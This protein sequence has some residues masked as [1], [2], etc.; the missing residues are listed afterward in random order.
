[1]TFR[2][3]VVLALITAAFYAPA[4]RTDF[5]A[6]DRQ[7]I[8]KN[9]LADDVP[10]ALRS[11]VEDY[12]GALGGE[13]FVYFRP[14]TVLTH[15]IDTRLWGRSPAGHHASNI[16]L[17]AIVTLLVFAF[18]L[19]L[20][21]G[22]DR[23]CFAGALLFG[24]H[25]IHTHSVIYVVGRTDVL[26][27]LFCLLSLLVLCRQRCTAAQQVLGALFYLAALLCKEIAVTLPLLYALY[28]LAAPGGRP[29]A[30]QI[31]RA[32]VLLAAALAL[33]L[34]MRVQAVGAGAGPEA[35]VSYGPV[36]RVLLV[37]MTLGFYCAKLLMPVNLCYYS[38]LVVPHPGMAAPDILLVAGGVLCAALMCMFWRRGAA[39]MALAWTGI[40]LLPVL[41]IIALPVLAKENYLYLPSV[42][43]CLLAALAA[44]RAGRL[45]GGRIAALLVAAIALLYGMQ[46]CLRTLDYRDPAL[47]L[48]SAVRAMR[49]LSRD[50]VENKNCFEGAKNWFTTCRN[51]GYLYVEKNSPAEAEQWFERA[52]DFTPAYFDPRYGAECRQALGE[53]YLK[54]GR[55][56]EARSQLNAALTGAHRPQVVYNLLGAAAAMQGDLQAAEDC[57]VQALAI[58]PGF[59][60]ARDNLERLRKKRAPAGRSS[61]PFSR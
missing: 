18:F 41:N 3:A 14:L 29:S 44:G 49:P 46:L 47:Y 59:A 25:P 13:S 1:M 54:Q 9:E 23:V 58:D 61:A 55:V 26:A 10:T 8:S 30:A 11:F 6:G 52:L 40:T 2:L 50:E 12:W 24:L 43:F 53:L 15:C 56:R 31:R 35:G 16:V 4:L 28:C 27:S 57:F 37:F 33:Y 32:A 22:R 60:A 36:Q 42:G 20:L 7:F 38:N 17:H 5:V 34:A 21:P 45:L 48:L 39:G 19:R 51:L